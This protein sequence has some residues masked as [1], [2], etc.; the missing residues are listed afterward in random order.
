MLQDDPPT[1][2]FDA[3]KSLLAAIES[4][5]L[6]YPVRASFA[7]TSIFFA[8]LLTFI[9]PCFETND[10]VGMSMIA[11]GTGLSARPDEHL[12]FSNVV[13]GLI[14]KRLYE[15]MP[16]VP[17]Y[18]LYLISLNYVSHVAVMSS[19]LTWRYRRSVAVCYFFIFCTVGVQLLVMLQF[20]STAAWATEC[21]L[22]VLFTAI[23]RRRD[24]PTANV[25]GMLATSAGLMFLG[26]LVRFESYVFTMAVGSVPIAVL[27][28]LSDRRTERANRTWR[29]AI[30]TGLATQ[31]A[32]MGC[33]AANYAY[34]N[35]DSGWQEF[36]VFNPY[37]A[38][39]NDWQWTKFNAQSKP[40]FDKVGWSENDY[41]LITNY[42]FFDDDRVFSRQ[43]LQTIV[44]GYPWIKS[45]VRIPN[46]LLCWFELLKQPY[47][48]L[49]WIQIPLQLWLARNRRQAIYHTLLAAVCIDT[50]VCG[51]MLIKPPVFRV[52]YP[53]FAF[54]LL[55]SLISMRWSEANDD[56][57]LSELFLS[58]RRIIVEITSL[59]RFRFSAVKQQVR[60]GVIVFLIA[61]MGVGI[62][63]SKA[64]TLS[65]IHL[66]AN[67]QMRSD[68][69]K[70]NPRDDELYV[71]WGCC[72]PYEAVLP[73]DS[74]D[75]L[76]NFHLLC[77]G[78]PQK[79]P[80][81]YAQKTR[82]HIQ[83]MNLDLR[84]NPKIYLLSSIYLN[85][86]Y[87]QFFQ[88][89]YQAEISWE[90]RFACPSFEIWKPIESS[91]SADVNLDEVP[92]R[93]PLQ[94]AAATD[95][96]SGPAAWR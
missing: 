96:S 68:I 50:I 6:R 24:Q 95:N 40:I 84:D 35:S 9:S 71:A 66:A 22:I 91:E 48:W 18:G 11:S 53:L 5:A 89:H 29:L 85:P 13:I 94:N 33:L 47:L 54:Q 69:A 36:L 14:L 19:L 79:S 80:I 25:M 52:Y 20:T 57:R 16:S 28:W 67:K 77:L 87:K 49:L 31:V 7:L 38:M 60:W 76:R 46:F 23:C 58:F 39:F 81:N 43:K 37:R 70:T 30:V 62:T 41:A 73:L 10:D 12:V 3:V 88:E 34:Y 27:I 2:R 82:F 63:F 90:R 32:V 55:F 64:R 17:W 74:P 15:L 59:Q 44:D 42:W 26:S 8:V 45:V 92:K 86:F 72:F 21:G 61:V 56:L 1:T 78:W 75:V 83:D 65:R 4:L 51:L 93:Q